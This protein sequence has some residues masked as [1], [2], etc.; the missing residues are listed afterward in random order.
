MSTYKE[1]LQTIEDPIKSLVILFSFFEGKE[2]PDVVLDKALATSLE[3]MLDAQVLSGNK[4]S[5]I[6]LNLIKHFCIAC[7]EVARLRYQLEHEHN[8]RATK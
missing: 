3:G 4:L 6:E 1:C 2:L 5:T 8:P 7:V